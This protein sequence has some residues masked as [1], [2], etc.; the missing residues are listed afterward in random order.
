MIFYWFLYVRYITETRKLKLKDWINTRGE[1]LWKLNIVESRAISRG[2]RWGKW[3]NFIP[4]LILSFRTLA[5][6]A[7][8]YGLNFYTHNIVKATAAWPTCANDAQSVNC[9]KAGFSNF[10]CSSWKDSGSNWLKV[11][12][13]GFRYT[14]RWIS[15]EYDSPEIF[16]TENGFSTRDTI[17]GSQNSSG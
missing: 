13:W 4:I 15:Q 17:E 12:P 10:K 1:K 16:V 7:D 2:N 5:G 3:S 14:L 11:A 8:F 6:S 9:D